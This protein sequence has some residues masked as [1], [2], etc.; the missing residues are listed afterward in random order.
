MMPGED[1]LT[2]CERLRQTRATP[3]LMI[4]AR[5][6]SDDRAIANIVGNAVRYGG[7]VEV[8]VDDRGP[9]V[10]ASEREAVFAPF[11]R[12]ERSRSRETG[13]SGLGLAVARGIVAQHGGAR[14]TVRLPA[15]DGQS[16]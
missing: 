1:G 10:A 9:G 15:S 6:L 8:V 16:V 11:H 14:F 4:S 2:F 3:I 13:G 7:A 12:G 5:S